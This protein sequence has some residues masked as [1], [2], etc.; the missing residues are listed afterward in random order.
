MSRF[1]KT[2]QS[3]RFRLRYRYIEID[4]RK[5]FT[6]VHD[7]LCSLHGAIVGA[8]VGAAVGAAVGARVVGARVGA[9]VLVFCLVGLVTALSV[10]FPRL[11]IKRGEP[12][13]ICGARPQRVNV[14]DTALVQPSVHKTNCTSLGISRQGYTSPSSMYGY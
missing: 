6:Y 1:V 7:V 9:E 4:E 10:A 2:T 3:L 14:P 13:F 12:R 11:E 8:R 5:K